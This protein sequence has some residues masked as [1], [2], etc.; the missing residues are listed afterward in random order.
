MGRREQVG[1]VA[2]RASAAARLP[3]IAVAVA[4]T[5]AIGCTGSEADTA[6]GAEELVG[7]RTIEPDE[8]R[9]FL[10]EHDRLVTPALTT[11]VEDYIACDAQRPKRTEG[12]LWLRLEATAE[13]ADRIAADM[14]D[15]DEVAD[16]T[17]LDREATYEQFVSYFSEEPDVLDAVGPDDLPTSF[18]IVFETDGWED[19][20]IDQVT[21]L[22]GVDEVDVVQYRLGTECQS[23]ILTVREACI[24]AVQ[25]AD[26]VEGA[27]QQSDSAL[28][29][30][31]C[32]QWSPGRRVP[33]GS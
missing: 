27:D 15:D 19:A 16:V 12:T 8:A 28:I 5:L 29:D 3:V 24:E 20:R 2:A 23:E 26:G 30:E 25:E 17:Y 11:A 13:Q 6:E 22:P 4:L 1:Q 7:W 18:E 10:A 21:S 9:R 31:R 32:A 14:A 33:L